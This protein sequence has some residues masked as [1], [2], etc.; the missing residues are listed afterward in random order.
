MGADHSSASFFAHSFSFCS[1]F[2][3]FVGL[4]EEWLER[5]VRVLVNRDEVLVSEGE[6]VLL[7]F[8]EALS[9]SEEE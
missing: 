2:F 8:G 1:F 9:F 7:L 4:L 3:V 5:Q 6:R